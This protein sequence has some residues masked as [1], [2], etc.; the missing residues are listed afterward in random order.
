VFEVACWKGILPDSGM[1]ASHQATGQELA[2]FGPT[3]PEPVDHEADSVDQT[4]AG[5]AVEV[6]RPPRLARLMM[7]NGESTGRAVNQSR[8]GTL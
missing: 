3:P 2:C 1:R 6:G 7:I 5:S 4:E 8:I